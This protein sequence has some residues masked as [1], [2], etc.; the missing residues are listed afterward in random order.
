MHYLAIVTSLVSFFRCLGGILALTI[1][2]SVVNNKVA[3]AFPD[4]SSDN[5][6]LSSLNGIKSLP[7]AV[8]TAVQDAF[9]NAVR[10]AYIAILPFVCINALS[11]IFL[12]EVKIEK[13]PAERAEHEAQQVKTDEELGQIPRTDEDGTT[14]TAAPQRPAHKPRIKIYGPVTVIIWCCQALGDKMGWRK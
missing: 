9:A 11:T 5:S 4:V 12:R 2:S 6:Q 7:P 8:L 14:T 10:W 1:M 3:S 13:T